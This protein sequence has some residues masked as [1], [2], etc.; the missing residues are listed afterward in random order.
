MQAVERQIRH[1]RAALW[2][3]PAFANWCRTRS[4]ELTRSGRPFEIVLVWGRRRFRIGNVPDGKPYFALELAD[5]TLE[6]SP[7]AE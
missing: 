1:L 3:E 7:L 2:L 5:G 6:R 4:Y